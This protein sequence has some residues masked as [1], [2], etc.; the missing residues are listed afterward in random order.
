MFYRVLEAFRWI[1]GFVPKSA[2]GSPVVFRVVHY[3]AWF[4]IILLA[5]I[6]SPVFRDPDKL[7]QAHYG[8]FVQNF[9]LGIV[10]FLCYLL[11]KAIVYVL[12]LLRIEDRPEFEDIERCWFAGMEALDRERL[13]F[14]WVPVFL[15]NGLTPKQEK[16]VFKAVDVAWKVVA[17]PLEDTGAVLRFFANDDQIFISC[18]GVGAMNR[19]LTKPL[20][21]SAPGQSSIAGGN[22]GGAPTG[23]MMSPGSGPSGPAPPPPVSGG[24]LGT[25]VAGPRPGGAP[26]APTGTIPAGPAPA[27][28]PAGGGGGV[29]GTIRS[30]G[31]FVAQRT[32]M[33][34]G[35]SRVAAASNDG[36][37]N[38]AQAAIIRPDEVEFGLKRMAYVCDLLLRERHPYCPINGMLQASPLEWSGEERLT[39]EL[40]PVAVHDLREVHSKLGLQFPVAFVLTGLDQVS[41]LPG[42]LRRCTELEPQFKQSRAGSRFSSGAEISEKNCEWVVDKG[43]RWFRD[44]VYAVF[45]TNLRD[46]DNRRLYHLLCELQQRRERLSSQLRLSFAGVSRSPTVRLAGCYFAATGEASNYQGFL[47]GIL[48]RLVDTQ[49][50]VAWH[51]EHI[52]RDASSKRWAYVL[53]TVAALLLVGHVLLY[54]MYGKS[55]T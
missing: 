44:W 22:M 9:W 2:V 8:P 30:M 3:T 17:P 35:M 11:G 45:A 52:Q 20:E 34:G 18:T 10:I 29:L 51:P 40:S 43:L 32:M 39:N 4:L 54:F 19:Q 15:V 38:K 37:A 25:Q 41:G 26:P 27:P 5:G 53:F 12:G 46:A 23:T 6:F 14:S 31:S 21:I 24:P 42:F 48:Q 47:K 36:N 1:F 55:L 49:A 28:A 13:D 16:S 33:P 7:R 50:E